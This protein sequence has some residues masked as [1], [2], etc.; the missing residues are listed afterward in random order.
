[1]N[2]AVHEVLKKTGALDIIGADNVFP[3]T[4]R[5][6]AAENMAWDAAQQWL[7]AHAPTP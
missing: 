1:V 3:A 7:K 4:K 6:L 5:V 2:P